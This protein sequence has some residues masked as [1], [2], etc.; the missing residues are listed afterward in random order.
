MRRKRLNNKK[1]IIIVVVLLLCLMIGYAFLSTDLNILGIANVK[2][3]KWDVHFANIRESDGI[4]DVDNTGKR[5]TIDEPNKVIYSVKLNKPGDYYEFLVDV[6]NEGTLNAK[7][8]LVTSL[9]KIN[10]EEK[11]L[12]NL[13]KWLIYKVEYEDGNVIEK[14]HIL[15]SEGT[16]TYRVRVEFNK[17]ISKDEL[18][19]EEQTVELELETDYIQGDKDVDKDKYIIV[20]NSNGG[21]GTTQPK[22]CEKNKDCT[23]N[24]NRF[25]YEGHNFNIDALFGT[26][27]SV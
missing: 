16:E 15:L 7:V 25:L 17:D 14:N 2:T 23:L 27:L 9:I 3:M 20:F 13:P 18:P 11:E 1:P 6:V 10:N 21:T 8:D 4:V 19:N 26:N 5:A 24:A 12:D 22:E